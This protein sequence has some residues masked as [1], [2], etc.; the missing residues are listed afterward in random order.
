M[1]VEPT[2][3]LPVDPEALREDVREKYR[4]VASDPGGDHH[5]HTGRYLARHLGYDEAWVEPMPERVIESFAGIANPFELRRLEPG[6]RVVDVGS[7]AGYDTLVAAQQVGD[8][9]QVVGVDM[10]E[11]MLAKARGNAELIGADN[12]EF[13]PGL[14]E[15][16]PVEDGWA[17]TVISNGVFNLCPD[18]LAMFQEVYRVIRPGGH[19]QFGDIANGAP[20][21]EE[22]VREIDLWTG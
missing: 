1:T 14:A 10:T 18:K 3:H 13:R 21:P 19:L 7:G 17:D 15:Q 22:A 20:V 6:E 16:L 2:E 12:V 4:E 11:E 5:F 8:D 9:G